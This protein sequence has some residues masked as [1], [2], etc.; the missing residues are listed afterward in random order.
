[1]RSTTL[2]ASLLLA[3]LAIAGCKE[4]AAEPT[5]EKKADKAEAPGDEPEEAGPSASIDA[6]RL[7]VFEELPEEFATEDNPITPEKVEL[8]RMLYYETRLSKSQEISCNT[9]HL[10][11]EYG[12]DHLPTSRGHEDAEGPRNAPTVYNA[13]GQVAQ[14]WDGRAADVEEQ[15][16]GPVTNP[17]EM[18]M[19]DGDYAVN[20]LKSIPGYAEPFAKAFPDDEAPISFEN[21]GDA[22][23]AFERKLVTPSRWDAF[24][25]GDE[26][27]LTEAEKKGFNVFYDTGCISCHTQE[28]V[29]GEQFQ[30]LG[31]IK[32]W[33]SEEDL[34]RYE[35]TEKEADKMVFR[36]PQL[37]NVEKTAPYFHDGQVKTLEEAVKLMG[38]H[39]L[40][41]KLSDEEV[42]HIVTWLKT[43]TGDLP[44]DE[45]IAEPELP[46]SGPDTPKPETGEGEEPESEED[47]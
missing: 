8:G 23:G 15:A 47:G 32:P 25:A 14:F 36:V 46:E 40:G 19:P 16:L 6:E 12:V 44:P 33:P 17:I 18:A 1:M 41:K 10:L 35:V 22:I 43:L 39:Q 37:R 13:A 7:K 34:G 29:G 45:L 24:L 5:E 21:I 38:E 9:C 4:E 3:S 30:K 2:I 26:D 42:Q 20:V 31:Q 28:L 11:D 27:A